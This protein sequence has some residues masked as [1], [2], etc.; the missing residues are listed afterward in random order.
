MKE[1]ERKKE[2]EKSGGTQTTKR[3]TPLYMVQLQTWS[4]ELELLFAGLLG[5]FFGS[6]YV[7]Q[8]VPLL[9]L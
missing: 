6:S 1:R 3:R 5:L 4:L 7:V 2:R 8:K 9:H